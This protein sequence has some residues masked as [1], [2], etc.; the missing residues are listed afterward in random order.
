MQL[1]IQ[2]IYNLAA[3][4]F[5]AATSAVRASVS[6]ARQKFV[7]PGESLSVALTRNL[8]KLWAPVKR[9]AV[10]AGVMGYSSQVL[11]ADMSTTVA[12]WASQHQVIAVFG[13][14]V[15]WH[16]STL[17]PLITLWRRQIKAD[18]AKEKLRL[19]QSASLPNG[20]DAARVQSMKPSDGT[21]VWS[22]HRG[23]DWDKPVTMAD[24]HKLK[25]ETPETPGRL[26][27][28]IGN[29]H[30]LEVM[31]TAFEMLFKL[32][33]ERAYSTLLIKA[34]TTID[35]H[36]GWCAVS[37]IA[38]YKGHAAR[39][40]LLSLAHRANLVS[41]SVDALWKFHQLF[42]DR[43]FDDYRRLSWSGTQNVA[44]LAVAY[45]ANRRDQ[46]TLLELCA[47]SRNHPNH[48]VRDRARY[49]LAKNFGR[50]SI[51][52]LTQQIISRTM[53]VTD[54]L[55]ALYCLGDIRDPM[56]LPA[57]EE[58]FQRSRYKLDL[59]F[60]SVIGAELAFARARVNTLQND[61]VGGPY[62]QTHFATAGISEE[63]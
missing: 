12:G 39:D 8:S 58:L 44:E 1:R 49:R 25:S 42:G 16:V 3:T 57:L 23:I 61:S 47:L 48:F 22:L 45:L 62:W 13:G 11:A 41:V 37:L 34:R 51:P 21:S 50:V 17:G 15:L 5:H 55:D 14:L 20:E 33:R 28:I 53:S 31:I 30:D 59:N 4:E 18:E 26:A 7:A 2:S 60:Q 52:I 35:A 24:L 27:T 32:D 19:L 46:E 38:Q 54:R 63:Q 9:L 36:L 10:P 40:D 56:V 6:S 29:T 43:G